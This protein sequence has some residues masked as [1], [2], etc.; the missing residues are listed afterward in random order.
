MGLLQRMGLVFIS[1]LNS[2]HGVTADDAFTVSQHVSKAHL[3][4]NGCIELA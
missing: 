4:E 2:L 3:E 1:Q